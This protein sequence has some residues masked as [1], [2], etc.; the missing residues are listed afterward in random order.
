[1]Q[2]EHLHRP[3]RRATGIVAVG[4]HRLLH[5]QCPI[6]T[7]A[8]FELV[9]GGDQLKKYGAVAAAALVLLVLIWIA[10]RRS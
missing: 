10:R 7:W 2:A 4:I 6:L 8:E 1:M 3:A 9:A 5:N